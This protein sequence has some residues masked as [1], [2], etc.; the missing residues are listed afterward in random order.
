[1]EKRKEIPYLEAFMVLYQNPTLSCSSNQKPRESVNTSD[2]LDDPLP[3]F[4]NTQ[5]RKTKPHLLPRTTY[6]SGAL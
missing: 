4:P 3:T 2:V 6:F 1:M 5:V